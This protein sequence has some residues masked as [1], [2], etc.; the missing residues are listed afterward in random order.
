MDD[1]PHGVHKLDRRTEVVTLA[2][3]RG[4]R[5]A[6]LGP[7]ELLR[8]ELQVLRLTVEGLAPGVLALPEARPAEGQREVAFADFL[9]AGHGPR[10]PLEEAEDLAVVLAHLVEEGLGQR[11][12]PRAVCRRMVLLPLGPVD[13]D[14]VRQPAPVEEPRQDLG[15]PHREVGSS[16]ALFHRL[17]GLCE[18]FVEQAR[19][20]QAGYDEVRGLNLE[21]VR[22][23][24]GKVHGAAPGVQE[25][26]L[27]Q[28]LHHEARVVRDLLL[29]GRRLRAE[30]GHGET[31][32]KRLREVL[33]V[34]RNG[35]F[36]FLVEQHH[37]PL[38]QNTEEHRRG[39]DELSGEGR[40]V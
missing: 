22:G 23:E 21:H 28:E 11:R 1:L 25:V 10:E 24:V 14:D 6:C 18:V 34:P 40:E 20:E 4:E 38:V 36:L 32:D 29:Q 30:E 16:Y 35:L 13:G 7:H 31:G 26:L 12:E 2:R 33:L 27:V 39:K 3:N 9:R 5:R 15:K 37:L 8:V 19:R 17:R